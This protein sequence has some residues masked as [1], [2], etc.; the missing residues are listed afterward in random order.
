MFQTF[1]LAGTSREP[2]F[3]S[4][5]LPLCLKFNYNVNPIAQPFATRNYLSV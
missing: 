5:S 4:R 2:L 1:S 3:V